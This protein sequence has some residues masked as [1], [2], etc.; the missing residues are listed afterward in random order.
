MKKGLVIVAVAT[1]MFAQASFAAVNTK[2]VEAMRSGV[3]RVAKELSGAKSPAERLAVVVRNAKAAVEVATIKAS[4]PEDVRSKIDQGLTVNPSLGVTAKVVEERLTSLIAATE[5]AKVGAGTAES[6]TLNSIAVEL[7]KL[8]SRMN[9]LSRND[10]ARELGD[11]VDVATETLNKLVTMGEMLP[12]MEAG[13]RAKYLQTI[14]EF[15]KLSA[16]ELPEVAILKALS[17]ALTG[18][19]D[20]YLAESNIA[21]A[22]EIISCTK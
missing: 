6:A 1:S 8:L 3:E 2:V 15:N 12:T 19:A 22:R 20:G 10:A 11:K 9:T 21:K 13:Q 16:T 4:I 7:T 17:I 5:A 14:T 18:S